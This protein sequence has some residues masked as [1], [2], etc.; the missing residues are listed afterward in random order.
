MRHLFAAIA[1]TASLLA[2][3]ASANVLTA[4]GTGWIN[5]AGSANAGGFA[6]GTHNNYVGFEA[7]LQYTNWFS[8]VLPNTKVKSATLNI[9]N[10]SNNTTIDPS[11]VYDLHAA[12]SFTYAGLGA[13]GSLGSITFGTA[14]TGVSRFVDIALNQT[15]V[16]FV[17]AHRGSSIEIGGTVTT[18]FDTS[19]CFDCIAAFGYTGGQPTATLSTTAVPEPASWALMIAG[20]GLVGATMRRR[21]AIAA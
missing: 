3:A 11:A 21:T 10:V 20:F 7:P 16:A 19:S 17:N 9:Y 1:V 12:T 8:F 6:S 14:D 4:T 5:S 15:G 18:A 2:G 13:G